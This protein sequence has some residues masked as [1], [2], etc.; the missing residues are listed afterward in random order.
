MS[1]L[2]F[3]RA[4]E[5]INDQH[6]VDSSDVKASALRRKV[7]IA[8]WHIPGCISESFT[9]C[10]TKKDAIECAVSY[11]GADG[12]DAINHAVR[13]IVTALRKYGYFSHHTELFGMVRTEIHRCTLADIVG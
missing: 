9:V 4:L 8:E 3:D 12:S 1:K 5:R 11:T 10:L 2:D 7:W 6:R 13:G